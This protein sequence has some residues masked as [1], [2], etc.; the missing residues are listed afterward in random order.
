MR[1]GKMISG[2]IS[3]GPWILKK[4]SLDLDRQDEGGALVSWEDPGSS[5]D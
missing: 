5:G 3:A 4:K 1:V 2:G